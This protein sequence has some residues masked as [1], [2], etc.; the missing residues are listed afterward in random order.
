MKF[1]TNK[2]LVAGA[3]WQRMRKRDGDTFMPMDR[4]VLDVADLDALL[5]LVDEHGSVAIESPVPGRDP[6]L[7]CLNIG[8]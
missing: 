1:E 7:P 6:S 2:L 8:S 5:R 3:A 4:P